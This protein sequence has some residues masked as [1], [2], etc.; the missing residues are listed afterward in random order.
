[1]GLEAGER[2][3]GW[4]MIFVQPASGVYLHLPRIKACILALRN[5]THFVSIKI[6]MEMPTRSL[7]VSLARFYSKL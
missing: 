3:R 2:R 6:R 1:M 5:M 7:S 4:G